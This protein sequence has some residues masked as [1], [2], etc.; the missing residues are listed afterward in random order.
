MKNVVNLHSFL[1]EFYVNLFQEFPSP[2]V[3]GTVFVTS[4]IVINR[5]VCLSVELL[6]FSIPFRVWGL[7]H[8]VKIMCRISFCPRRSISTRVSYQHH[9]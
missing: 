6:E 8:T 4:R 2:F 1:I 7:G 5:D 9:L 3:L